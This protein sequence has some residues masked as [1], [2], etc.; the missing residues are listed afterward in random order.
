M[1][2]F[3]R[4]VGAVISVISFVT[5]SPVQHGIENQTPLQLPNQLPEPVDRYMEPV[6]PVQHAIDS[7]SDSVPSD[8]GPIFAPPGTPA[9]D[10][11]LCDYTAMSSDWVACSNTTRECWLENTQTQEQFNITTPYEDLTPTGILRQYS[12]EI[13][14]DSYDADGMEF[15][16][17]KLFKY[18]GDTKPSQYPGPWI[19]AC[20]GDTVEV[21]VTN[22]M[23]HNGTSVHWHGVRQLLTMHMD[24]VNGITQCPIAPLDTFVYKFR[25]MQYGSSWYHTHYS[26]QYADGAV[27][28]MTFHGP[29]SAEYDEAISPPLI[30]TDWGHNSAFDAVYQGLTSPDILLN[31]RGNVTQFNNA[32]PN[33]TIVQPP[34]QKSFD[35]DPPT[36]KYLF[37]VINTSFD[38]TFIFSIDNHLLQVVSADF[39][40]IEPYTTSSILVG[41]GQRYNVIVEANP[42]SNNNTGPIAADGNYWIRTF[43][44]DCGG[45]QGVSPNYMETGIL[46]Y[47]S[48]SPATPT[49]TEWTD[50]SPQECGD[51]PY[52][53]LIPKVNWTIGDASNGPNGEQFDLWIDFRGKS[54]YPLAKWTLA[55]EVDGGDQFDPM[56]VNYS[57]PTFLNLDTDGPWV[58]SWRIVPEDYTSTDWIFLAIIP[59]SSGSTGAHPIHL[60]GHDFAI[61]EQA[62]NKAYHPST[63]NLKTDNPPRRDVVLVD[64]SGYVVIAFKADNAGACELDLA[65]PPGG[66][67]TSPA[68]I[69]AKRVCGKWKAWYGDEGNWAAPGAACGQTDPAMCF[70]D[71][72]GV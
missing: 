45:H 69:E 15:N 21:S 44:A 9:E 27:G 4:V 67:D 5:L 36:K 11:F 8:V 3:D 66:P 42:V 59:G 25:V 47:N 6:R 14:D 46:R 33:T 18:L 19:Q 22:N 2:F 50:F 63:L 41:I 23:A 55:A 26:V 64:T 37:R 43:T 34:Y 65:K 60:H 40:A 7:S 57:N 30:M 10:G 28:P 29:M 20:W 58:K 70:Q 53:S 35:G 72:S 31:G 17:A 54:V 49:T 39:V 38:M 16:E 68:I 51:E 52:A 32:V 56:R 48:S 61:L 24:G 1:H 13:V 71:D 62:S 12:L